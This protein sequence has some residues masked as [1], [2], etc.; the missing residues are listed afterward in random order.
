MLKTKNK[1][2]VGLNSLIKSGNAVGREIVCSYLGKVRAGTVYNCG[3]GPSGPFITLKHIEGFYRT[4][5][6]KKMKLAV[7]LP[8]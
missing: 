8:K 7:I 2:N 3:Q 6:L 4:L 5:S 1:F